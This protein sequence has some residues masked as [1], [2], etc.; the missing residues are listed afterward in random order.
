[1]A[2]TSV[3]TG[4]TKIETEVSKSELIELLEA[5][6]L[7]DKFAMSAL[8]AFIRELGFKRVNQYGNEV[9]GHTNGITEFIPDYKRLSQFSYKMADAMIEIRKVKLEK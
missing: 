3:G 5:E 9:T 6:D 2:A 7:R 4:I 1:M 8:N